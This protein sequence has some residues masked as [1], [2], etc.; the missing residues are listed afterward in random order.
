M[1]AVELHV[2]AAYYV[3]HPPLK[4]AYGKIQ[5]VIGGKLFLVYR[6]VFELTQGLRDCT[7]PKKI[8]TGREQGFK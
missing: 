1:A 2:N 6:T 3:Q 7:I 8:Q 5:S 4:S